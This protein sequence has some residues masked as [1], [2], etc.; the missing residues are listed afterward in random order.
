MYLLVALAV[1]NL[2]AKTESFIKDYLLSYPQS[3]Q[4][5]IRQ[6][7]QWD[8]DDWLTAGGIIFIGTGLYLFDE[9]INAL[10]QR[11]RT[12]FS[13]QAADFANQFGEG[14]YVVSALSVTWLGGYL[15]DST[16]TQ[17]TALLS[18]KSFVLANGVTYGL[19]ILTQRQRPS[20]GKGKQFFTGSGFT[21]KTKSFPSGHTTI[22][23]SVA[24]ILAEQYKDTRWLPPAVYSIA[25]LTSLARIHNHRHWSSDV[26][27]GA[28]IGYFSSQLVLKST[29]RLEFAYTLEPQGINLGYRF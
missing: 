2:A 8:S 29:P 26:F 16:Q 24:P 27:A 3:A 28:A 14:K 15:F 21:E 9:E 7:F 5:A 13:N 12:Q 6:P 17:D 10:A 1:C 20:I 25:V 4:E 18:L 11:N 23:W 22:V 19:K